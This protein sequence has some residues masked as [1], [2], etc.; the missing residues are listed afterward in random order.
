MSFFKMDSAFN[1]LFKKTA[2]SCLL[3][4]F[5]PLFCDWVAKERERIL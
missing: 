4:E 1:F 2:L 3:M 5:S